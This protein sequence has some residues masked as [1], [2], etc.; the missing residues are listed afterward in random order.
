MV[1]DLHH[2]FVKWSQHLDLTTDR[3]TFRA[4][5]FSAPTVVDIN[6]D[7]YM[8]IVV[9]TSEGF[10]YVLD[11]EGNV[12]PGWPIQMAA[13]ESQA[14]VADLNGDGEVEIFAG[15]VRVHFF[16]L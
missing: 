6:G 13:I 16:C 8:E 1:F 14:L 11:H 10:L 3:T 12:L 2:R 4:Y 15:E 7:G 9:G 5:L